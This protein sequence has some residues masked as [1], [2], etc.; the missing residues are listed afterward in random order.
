MDVKKFYPSIDK[1]IMKNVVRKKIK[2]TDTL[3]LIDDIIDSNCNGLP[4]GN[5]ISQYL[6][7]LYLSEIDHK[8]K[9][10]I[11]VKHYFRYCDDIIILCDSKPE[12]HRIRKY[13]NKE[14]KLLKLCLKKDY[15][16]RPTSVGV[17]VLGYVVTG[18]TIGVRRSIKDR[19]KARYTTKSAP[20]YN[21]WL[22][23]CNGHILKLV[24][25][26]RIDI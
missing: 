18:Y 15:S 23:H 12:L 19:M 17:D 16:V 8:L 11:R 14:L 20:S 24:L 4:I 13:V 1:S 10:G 22:S 25:D 7:N 3:W 21:G 26:K 6:G 5:Y 9:E 2:C